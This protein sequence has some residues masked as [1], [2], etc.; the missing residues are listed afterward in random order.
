[1][2]KFSRGEKALRA[3]TGIFTGGC[4]PCRASARKTH[5]QK[6]QPVSAPIS[7]SRINNDAND[8]NDDNDVNDVNDVSCMAISISCI[9]NDQ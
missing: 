1:M 4:S 2:D 5:L 9:N 7:I 6:G 8:V 3:A